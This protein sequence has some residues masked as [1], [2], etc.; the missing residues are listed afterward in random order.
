MKGAERRRSA[1]RLLG[2]LAEVHIGP[3]T[4]SARVMDISEH[5]LGVMVP[6]GTTVQVGDTVWIL[7]ETVA[8]YAITG[9]VRRTTEQGRVGIEFDEILEG[10]SRELIHQL[11]M[12]DEV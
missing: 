4:V 2:E 3:Q 11:P 9:T 5:G 7:I 10:P 1:R 12:V 8:N 6:S